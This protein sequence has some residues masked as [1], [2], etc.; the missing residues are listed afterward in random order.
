MRTTPLVFAPPTLDDL[1]GLRQVCEP[2]H[3]QALGPQGADERFHMRIVGWLPRSREVFGSKEW[4]LYSFACSRTPLIFTA[5]HA[6][7]NQSA[8]IR[9]EPDDCEDQR[10]HEK[11]QHPIAPRGSRRRQKGPAQEGSN[12]KLCQ[13]GS[14]QE[15]P[16]DSIFLSTP[17][18]ERLKSEFENALPFQSVTHHSIDNPPLASR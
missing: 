18:A 15:A 5:K 4:F 9:N 10:T 2:V 1:P 17:W 8:K 7:A 13:N 3:V 16:R 14:Q 12:P 6:Q 11:S